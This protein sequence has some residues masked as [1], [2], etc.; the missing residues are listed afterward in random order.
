MSQNKE[1]VLAN[2]FYFKIPEKKPDFVVGKVSCKV[3]DAIA[4]LQ[5]HEKNGWVNMDVKI[6][7]RTDKPYMSL[8]QWEPPADSGQ[9]QQEQPPIPPPA[10][11]GNRNETDIDDDIPF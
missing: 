5:Q 3:E 7:G 10:M 4:F 1:Q 8:D 2:G 6:S 9:Q 11:G